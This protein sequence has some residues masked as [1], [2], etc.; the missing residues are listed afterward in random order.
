[1][2]GGDCGE[3]NVRRYN[4]N[5]NRHLTYLICNS[6]QHLQILLHI[7][8]W[9]TKIHL[10]RHMRMRAHTH[11]H[12]HTHAYTHTHTHTHMHACTH[13]HTHTH[14]HTKYDTKKT[15]PESTNQLQ[16]IS[17]MCV[18]PTCSNSCTNYTA[19]TGGKQRKLIIKR[20]KF[21]TS[22]S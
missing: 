6:P 14:T 9:T 8:I 7:H 17:L 5:N 11:A 15:V 3:R 13:K 20:M 16:M 10:H 2:C 19:M 22:C 21:F 18:I 1:M 4:N 12:T